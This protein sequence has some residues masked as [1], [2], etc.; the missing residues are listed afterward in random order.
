MPIRF[1]PTCR[2]ASPAA[3]LPI[4]PTHSVDRISILNWAGLTPRYPKVPVIEGFTARTAIAFDLMRV[5]FKALPRLPSLLP[6]IRELFK[7]LD[8]EE[9][10]ADPEGPRY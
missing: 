5:D 8:E 1:R 9:E 10:V 3:P 2:S 6:S 4:N 7:G